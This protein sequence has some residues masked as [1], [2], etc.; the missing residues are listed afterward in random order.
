MDSISGRLNSNNLI[1]SML[2]GCGAAVT[3][4]APDSPK[5][6]GTFGIRLM[7]IVLLYCD[8]NRSFAGSSNES[9]D[10]WTLL[11]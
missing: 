3:P 7:L 10:S 11:L 1:F 9:S 2:G 6:P 5:A 4:G 8:C